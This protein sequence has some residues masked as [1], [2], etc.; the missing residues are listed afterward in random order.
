VLLL[1][2]RKERFKSVKTK[3]IVAGEKSSNTTISTRTYMLSRRG[4]KKTKMHNFLL[5]PYGKKEKRKKR[6]KRREMQIKMQPGHT[7][8]T[9]KK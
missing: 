8:S 1:L 9:L 5:T 4:F 2:K 7:E 6:K 3:L